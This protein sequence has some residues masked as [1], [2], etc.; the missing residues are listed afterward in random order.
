MVRMNQKLKH[1]RADVWERPDEGI[2]KWNVDGAVRGAPG[3]GVIGGVLHD[4]RGEIRGFF[5]VAVGV[6]FAYEAEVK[7]KAIRKAIEF[8]KEYGLRRV[9]V[10]SDSTL[11]VGWVKRRTN[12]PWKL[13]QDLHLID[14]LI[15]EVECLQVYHVYREVNGQADFLAK[16]GCDR[17]M[18]CKC[19]ILG[20]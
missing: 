17:S 8:C 15:I 10:E 5:S 6:I 1:V 14:I 11:V 20:M 2:L 3:V 18:R 12:R 7:A 16:S 13:L 4:S 9:V 19:I